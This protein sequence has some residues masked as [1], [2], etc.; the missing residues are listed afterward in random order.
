MAILDPVRSLATFGL[1][2]LLMGY[3][4][5]TA[6]AEEAA[7][8]VADLSGSASQLLPAASKPAE[9]QRP[10]KL[11]QS[12]ATGTAIALQDQASLTLYY[13]ASGMAYDLKGPGRFEVRPAEVVALDGAPQPLRRKL[14][15]VLQGIRL[16]GGRLAQAGLTMRGPEDAG[17]PMAL[18]PR[19]VVLSG[20]PL[21]MRW[22]SGRAGRTT[23]VLLIDEDG[24]KLFEGTALADSL[25]LPETVALK[26]GRSYFWGVRDSAAPEG[27]MAWVEFTIA[28]QGLRDYAAEIDRQ[29]NGGD[30]A[31]RNLRELLLAQRWRQ[32]RATAR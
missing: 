9:K 27:K 28:D 1:C 25:S 12:L 3:G 6:Q 30:P 22:N 5:G 24:R 7:V 23:T 19:G 4:P 8:L 13:V 16:Q 2:L 14:N 17:Q 10:L 32:S 11:L 18:S 15:D 26:P 20:S 21:V 31:E 29:L